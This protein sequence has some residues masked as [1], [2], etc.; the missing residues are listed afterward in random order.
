MFGTAF[1]P[2]GKP[3]GYG[4]AGVNFPRGYIRQHLFAFR[5]ENKSGASGT[6]VVE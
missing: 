5:R 2:P 3:S 4:L 6:G 1:R